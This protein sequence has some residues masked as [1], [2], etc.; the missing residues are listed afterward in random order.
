MCRSCMD[1]QSPAEERHVSQAGET[2]GKNV[3]LRRP[4]KR[5]PVSGATW[6]TPKL[7][8]NASDSIEARLRTNDG[9]QSLETTHD[10]LV[11][12]KITLLP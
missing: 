7:V 1:D 5:C 12:G 8:H 10:V 9:L 4:G 3:L 2:V 11:P 6:K